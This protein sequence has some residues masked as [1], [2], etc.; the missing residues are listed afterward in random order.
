MESERNALAGNK[1][2][3]GTRSAIKRLALRI[4]ALALGFLLLSAL[5]KPLDRLMDLEV[6]GPKLEHFRRHKDEYTVL[7]F[8]SSYF[9][10]E[11]SPAVFDRVSRERRSV[12]RSFNFG[13]PG[14]DPPE[15]YFLVERALAERPASLA[16]V[17]IE[18]D[19]FRTGVRPRNLHT[20]RFE[21]WHDPE[22]T[23]EVARAVLA[24]DASY[25]TKAKELANHTEAFGRRLLNVGWGRYYLDALLETKPS[26]EESRVALGPNRDGFLA[27]DE[28]TANVYGVRSE[29]FAAIEIDRFEE[30]RAELVRAL[31]SGSPGEER[32]YEFEERALHKVLTLVRRAGARPVLVVPPCLEPRTALIELARGRI[33]AD[34]LIFN[35]PTTFARLYD[36]DLRFDMGHLNGRGAA[37]FTRILAEHVAALGETAA[38]R[39]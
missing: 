2:E 18:L 35:N 9:H 24:R 7:F 1:R 5:I 14:M 15:T 16:W 34:L 10:R 38:D 22:R 13:I 27:L 21:Y 8:G 36:P 23:I 25:G 39:E 30:K 33:D 4:L 12:T 6:V 17:V 28:E 20:R 29:F 32:A 3:R 11:I 19:H 31:E 26:Q 37:E